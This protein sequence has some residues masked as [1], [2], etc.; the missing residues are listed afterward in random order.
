[1]DG[2]IPAASRASAAAAAA[3]MYAAYHCGPSPSPGPPPVAARRNSSASQA[4]ASR[5][6]V[7]AARSSPA[8]MMSIRL[9]FLTSHAPGAAPR[10]AAG[11]SFDYQ[12]GRRHR[13]VLTG[14]PG[15]RVGRAATARVRPGGHA[16]AVLAGKHRGGILADASE[17]R[18]GA[19]P[20]PTMPRRACRRESPVPSPVTGPA[21]PGG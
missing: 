13:R 14:G 21:R 15:R 11:I 7:P 2:A 17:P 12:P 16:R 8:V 4:A 20:Q 19:A 9:R 10:A 18:E 5:P 3:H 1:M 6:A